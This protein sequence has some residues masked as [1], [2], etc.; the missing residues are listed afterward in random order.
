MF[1]IRDVTKYICRGI[2]QT[3]FTALIFFIKSKR[4]L[5]SS[6]NDNKSSKLYINHPNRCARSRSCMDSCSNL[7]SNERYTIKNTITTVFRSTEQI[8]P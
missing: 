6:L 7:C 1:I 8:F 4:S 2:L 5:H 3:H